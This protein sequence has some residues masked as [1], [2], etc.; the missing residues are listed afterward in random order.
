M[1]AP[2]TDLS[3]LAA[4]HPSQC[5]DFQAREIKNSVR[6]QGTFNLSLLRP[7]K[8][9]ESSRPYVP[10]DPVNLIDWKAFARNDQLIVRERR[11]QASATVSIMLDSSET[12]DWP[13]R[14]SL[15]R[16]LPQ[17]PKKREIALRIA[18]NIAYFHLRAGDHVLVWLIQDANKKRP[19]LRFHPRS[20]TDVLG[21]FEFVGTEEFRQD[22]VRSRFNIAVE[23]ERSTDYRYWIGDCL[24]NGD[25]D[26][27]LGKGRRKYLIHTLSSLE[28]ATSWMKSDICYFDDALAGKEYL[29]AALTANDNYMNGLNDW[30]GRLK[31]RLNP[32][33]GGYFLATDSTGIDSYFDFLRFA[34]NKA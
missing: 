15:S 34:I 1:S 16:D 17:V 27:F 19:D 6:P 4:L 7:S 5:L 2:V 22:I 11:D 14:A 12:M 20:A 33:S 28:V 29:G 26:E 3:T 18:L 31:K 10:G 30:A 13:D 21:F 32:E 8:T 23:S 25:Y 9:P 24:G